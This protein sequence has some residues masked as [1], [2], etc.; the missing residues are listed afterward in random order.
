MAVIERFGRVV[1]KSDREF[2]I[3]ILACAGA[4][5]LAVTSVSLWIDEGFVVWVVSHPTL[6]TAIRSASSPYA[7]SPGDRQ[8]PFYDLWLWAWS[9][10]FGSSEYAMRAANMPFAVVYVLSLASASRLAFGKRFTWIP[11][12]F[13]PFVWFYMNEIRPY[14]MLTA[15][16]TA[17]TACVLIALFGTGRARRFARRLAF[18]VLLC[19]WASHILAILL[20]PGLGLL[21]FCT[22]RELDAG[23]RAAWRTAMLIAILP[24]LAIATYYASTLS[25][26]AASAEIANN[27]RGA[28]PIA[29]VLEIAYEH[30]GFAGL[31][32]DRNTLREMSG[33]RA[34]IPFAATLLFGLVGIT[35]A[36][37]R[38]IE[39]PIGKVTAYLF[40]GWAISLGLAMLATEATHARFLGRHLAGT[41]P[42]LTLAAIS[43]IRSRVALW[44]LLI[45]F[46]SSDLRL[47]LDARY[48]KDDY[49]GA[50]ESMIALDKAHPGYLNWAAD[51][52]TANYYGL[53]FVHQRNAGD[54][55]TPWRVRRVGVP[56]YNYRPQDAETLI[57][58]QISSGRPAYLALGKPDL[59]DMAHGWRTTIASL[60]GRQ[61]EHLRAFD[62]IMFPATDTQKRVHRP[63]HSSLQLGIKP[64]G[65][66]R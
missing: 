61:V 25:G 17:A 10:L 32:P 20:V 23:D 58:S 35:I 9:R 42:L 66:T 28:S 19:A 22:R 8:Y 43:T 14:M 12:A 37:V 55:R 52:L 41:L 34:Y 60:H 40:A 51:D 13:V 7:P 38:G 2:W 50:V 33:L 59:F 3:A 5:V 48:W 18:P 30:F 4:L 63:M 6:E 56:V 26:G 15:L 36:I 46:V 1:L 62:I 24:A 29:S 16:S 54:V 65:R 39:R 31:G 57:Q 64:T 47:T 11:F 44:A 21:T 45:V 27:D 49:R 53:S